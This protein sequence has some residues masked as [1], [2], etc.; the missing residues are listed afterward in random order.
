MNP[1]KQ[2]IRGKHKY[3]V[4]YLTAGY[5]DPDTFVQLAVAAAEAGADILEI[6]VPFSDPVADGPVI[7]YTDQKALDNGVVGLE[8]V[9][10][11]TESVKCKVNIPL[12]WMGYLN[13]Y[14][15]YGFAHSAQLAASAGIDAMIVPDLPHEESEE[16]RLA[17][18]EHDLAWIPL[19][20]STTREDRAR[21]MLSLAES[22]G[23]YV[24]V[25]GVTGARASY[26]EGWDEPL[27][28]FRT[29]DDTPVFVGFGVSG[30]AL[31]RTCVQSGDGVIVGS[32]L[33]DLVRKADTPQQAVHDVRRFV[34]SL[35]TAI[36]G[37]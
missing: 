26:P 13:L 15:S 35:R 12:V 18:A 33:L 22:F 31:A 3:L 10:S 11:L 20:T 21:A 32:A 28:R 1:L 29:M 8:T 14:M 23:Y 25:A 6:G 4:P 2:L 30:P 37:Q 34:T 36:D 5:P 17:L 9:A 19:L 24:A 27:K 7:Q 16:L